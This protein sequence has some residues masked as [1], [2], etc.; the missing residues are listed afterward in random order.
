MGWIPKLGSLWMAF[1]S[2][3]DPHFVFEKWM[4]LEIIL[5]SEVTQSLKNTHVIHPLISG[6]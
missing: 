3:S 6:Y 1:S 2:V 5:L 4:E